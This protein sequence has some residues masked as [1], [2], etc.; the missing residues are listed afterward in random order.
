MT[1]AQ[2]SCNVW[3]ASLDRSPKLGLDL[4]VL[5]LVEQIRR[6]SPV[7]QSVLTIDQ[8]CHS[9]YGLE[10]SHLI[11]RKLDIRQLYRSQHSIPVGGCRKPFGPANY[12]PKLS[13]DVV[14]GAACGLQV[15][16][17]NECLAHGVK[18]GLDHGTSCR[19]S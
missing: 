18:R 1:F 15:V 13:L 7:L 2:C 4:V 11:C 10:G 9:A 6:R 5:H 3:L 16:A 14:L 12:S 19:A 17:T 8:T